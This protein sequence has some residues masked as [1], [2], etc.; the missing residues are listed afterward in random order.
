MADE[1][2][3]AD[4]ITAAHSGLAAWVRERMDEPRDR[5]DPELTAKWAS[6]L[7]VIRHAERCRPLLREAADMIDAYSASLSEAG[8][9]STEERRADDLAGRL[10]R[11]ADGET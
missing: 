3:E 11:A 10:R 4:D 1:T 5:P 9:A 2:K 7:V 8:G 6:L